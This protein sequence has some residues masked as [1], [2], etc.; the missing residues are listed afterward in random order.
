MAAHPYPITL[1]IQLPTVNDKPELNGS[2][3]V[4]FSPFSFGL[5]VL[6]STCLPLQTQYFPP[7]CSFNG[8]YRHAPRE[9]PRN[10]SNNVDAFQDE[11]RSAERKGVEQQELAGQFE[12]GYGRYV[13]FGSQKVK[14]GGGSGC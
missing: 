14:G 3:L 4:F 7:C 6:T 8:D 9:N 5:K 13:G 1:Q 2:M 10:D 11:A 12:L